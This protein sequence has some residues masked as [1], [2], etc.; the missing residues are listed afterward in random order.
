MRYL[1]IRNADSLYWVGRYLQRFE[2]VAKESL[3]SFD[4]IIDIN[5]DDGKELFAKMEYNVS[6][7]SA[8]DFL[9]KISKDLDNGG[10]L[11]NIKHA[12]ENAIVLRDIIDDDAFSS[13]NIIYNELILSDTIDPQKLEYLIK[14]LDRFWGLVFFKIVRGKT[15]AFI[16]FGQVTEAI[17]LKLRLFGDFSMILFDLE[18]L[19]TLGKILDKDYIPVELRSSDIDT[20][21]DII[22]S[23]ISSV[24]KYDS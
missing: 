15:Q 19:N 17:D 5:F 24:I 10:L 21:L 3:K 6:Y 1:S 7:S 16:E 14:E 9:H 4:F 12:R 13:I 23:K 8:K 22:N 2:I 18:K 20:F 11:Y